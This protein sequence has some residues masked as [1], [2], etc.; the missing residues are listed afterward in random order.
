MSIGGTDAYDRIDGLP[1]L[2]CAA[3]DRAR[4]AGFGESCRPE[5]GRL[6]QVLAAGRPG[7]VI[8][9]TGTGCGVGLAWLASGAAPGTRLVSV[10]RDADRA[11]A[12]ADV[13]RDHDDVTVLHDGWHALLDLSLIHI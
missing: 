1:S 8:G 10:E 7:G 13:F 3:L 5:Q 9:E 12:A 2:V 6:L 4:A 11:R